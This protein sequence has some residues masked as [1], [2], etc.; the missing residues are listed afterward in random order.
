MTDVGQAREEDMGRFERQ[1]FFSLVSSALL[2]LWFSSRDRAGW[3]VRLKAVRAVACKVGRW[4]IGGGYGT[5]IGPHRDL[6]HQGY[7]QSLP[8]LI[9]R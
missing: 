5:I 6:G 4:G 1:A 3:P 9:A 8:P 2:A 7:H